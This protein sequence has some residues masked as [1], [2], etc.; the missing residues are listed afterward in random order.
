ISG[1]GSTTITA[2]AGSVLN[3]E[4]IVGAGGQEQLAYVQT[5]VGGLLTRPDTMPDIS[6]DIFAAFAFT[7]Y[8]EQGDYTNFFQYVVRS[9]ADLNTVTLLDQDSM[10]INGSN[11]FFDN[12]PLEIGTGD[13]NGD[14]IE[15]V[16]LLSRDGVRMFTVIQDQL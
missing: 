15:D 5:A 2:R 1:V 16:A 9:T 3:D 11:N 7:R 12:F 6:R 4:H 13:L 8:G 10:T 14:R